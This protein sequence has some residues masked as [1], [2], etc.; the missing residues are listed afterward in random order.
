MYKTAEEV[1]EEASGGGAATK[2]AAQPILDLRGPQARLVT[3]L[4]QLNATA[5]KDA[6]MVWMGAHSEFCCG[7]HMLSTSMQVLWLV[8]VAVG[9]PEAVLSGQHCGA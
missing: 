7:E 1:L 9:G 3:D 6:G 5:G 2:A 4:E 8:M